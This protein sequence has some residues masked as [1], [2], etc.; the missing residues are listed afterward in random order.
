MIVLRQKEYSQFSSSMKGAVKGAGKGA[1]WGLGLSTP[2]SISK[3]GKGKMKGALINSGVMTAVGAGVGAKVGWN[4]GKDAWKSEQLKKDFEAQKEGLCKKYRTEISEFQKLMNFYE[5][6]EKL[7]YFSTY[8]KKQ[9]PKLY[10]AWE[11]VMWGYIEQVTLFTDTSLAEFVMA[12]E[13][14]KPIKV[15]DVDLRYDDIQESFD[16]SY[17]HDWIENKFP[18][19]FPELRKDLYKFIESCH[20][21]SYFTPETAW[22]MEEDNGVWYDSFEDFKKD[23]ESILEYRWKYFSELE[24]IMK[25]IL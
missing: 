20:Q 14:K 19:T 25:K 11:D 2:V 18:V 5:A 15:L 4:S 1:L 17:D 22:E 6:V 23:F 10:K 9:S 8:L 7:G 12:L 13:T 3:V 21:N 16:I 24:K